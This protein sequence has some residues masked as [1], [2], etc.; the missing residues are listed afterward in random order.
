MY[1][2]WSAR[3]VEHCGAIA[4]ALLCAG[5]I[6]LGVLGKLPLYIHPRYTIFTL[7]MASV[8]LIVS[9]V[10]MMVGCRSRQTIKPAVYTGIRPTTMRVATALLLVMAC[11]GFLFVQPATLSSRT[12]VSRG[13]DRSPTLTDVS[14]SQA[15]FDTADYSQLGIKDWSSLLAHYDANFIVGKTASI[16]GFVADNGNANIFFAS[17]FFVTCCVVDAQ[18][19]GVPVYAPDWRHRYAPNSWLEITGEFIKNPDA[20]SPHNIV[21]KPSRIQSVALPREPYVY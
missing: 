2:K 10:S 1:C 18:P 8:G 21:L 6:R 20:D 4:M 19:I 14:V 5:I 11:A 12:A 16:T 7:V 13:I 17:R 15:L 3:Y 9:L